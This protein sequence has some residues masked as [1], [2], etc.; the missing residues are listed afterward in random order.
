[1]RVVYSDDTDLDDVRMASEHAF[2]RYTADI[3]AACASVSA[4]VTGKGILYTLPEMMISLAR[5]NIWIAPSG[6]HTAKS[7]EWRTP[8][9]KSFLVAAGSL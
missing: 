5:S 3:L 6:W 2:Q 1:M 8:P 7:P 4:G 9:A